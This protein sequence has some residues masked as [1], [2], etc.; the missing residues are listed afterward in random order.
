MDIK[1]ELEN[2]ISVI[3]VIVGS[4]ILKKLDIQGYNIMQNQYKRE[5]IHRPIPFLYNFK[6]EPY[7]IL[8]INIITFIFV[9][10]CTFRNQHKTIRVIR[11]LQVYLR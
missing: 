5:K 3:V 7:T 2:Q 4:P 6:I 11:Q 8:T 10:Q 9:F 1:P